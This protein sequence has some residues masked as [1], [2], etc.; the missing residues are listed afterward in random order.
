M[1]GVRKSIR[2]KKNPRQILSA[3]DNWNLYHT[4]S[5]AARVTNYRLCLGDQQGNGKYATGYKSKRNRGG[6]RVRMKMEKQIK[7][8][9]EQD[10]RTATLNVGT[11]TGRGNEIWDMMERRNLLVLCVQETKWKGSRRPEK[12]EMG[13]SCNTVAQETIGMEWVS[14]S[15]HPSL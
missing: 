11:M 12:L 6:K 14:S 15:T 13:T 9:Q 4:G 1:V 10:L 5:V 7:Q 2:P 8:G 3:N